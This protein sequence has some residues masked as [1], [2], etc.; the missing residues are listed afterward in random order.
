MVKF[1]IMIDIMQ[2][3]VNSPLRFI[4]SILADVLLICFSFALV[5]WV[6]FISDLIPVTRGMVPFSHFLPGAG[7][8]TA[9]WILIFYL[10]GHYDTRKSWRLLEEIY[11]IVK[12]GVI[13]SVLALA[14]TF[15]IR[16]FEYS[17][18]YMALS[19]T[20]AAFSVIVGRVVVRKIKIPFMRKG[21]LLFRTAI[22]GGGEMGMTI[23][24]V[25]ANP[26]YGYQIV[27]N[28][29]MNS[30][31]KTLGNIPTLGSINEVVS[32]IKKYF[33][34][35]LIMSFPLRTYE[36]IAQLVSTCKD[37][38]VRLLFAPDVYELVT[39]RVTPYEVNGLLLFGIKEYPLEGWYGGVKRCV[40]MVSA[41]VGLVITVPILLFS[42]MLIKLTSRGPIFYIQERVG[43]DKNPFAMIKF[44]TMIQNAEEHTGPVWAKKNDK[45][46]TPVGRVLR[47]MRI[48]ELPQLIN[49]LRGEMSV[50][51]PRPERDYF[52]KKLSET[53]PNYNER[54][55]ARPGI[56]GIAQIEHTYDRTVEDVEEKLKYDLY[57]LEN[58][59]PNL[60]MEI[61]IRTLWVVFAGKGAH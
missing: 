17:R 57:Y 12:G 47:R 16:P 8:V 30:N 33:I 35:T 32:I 13:A 2:G 49:V 27:G 60:D 22:L 26:V 61:A 19:I 46:I 11:E 44:R 50:I 53:V 43:L 24:K 39:Y 7:Y 21:K 40:D 5:Y 6:R 15:F 14:P 1:L 3:R 25:L 51:G 59:S 45:R 28:I 37:L 34:D 38:D 56:T 58:A 52:V 4:L 48:D 41:S 36:N 29:T 20:V 54:F 42:A 9:L 23:T 18:L 31:P 55:R 10:Q